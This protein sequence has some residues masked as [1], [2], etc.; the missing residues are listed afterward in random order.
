M[1]A[2]FLSVRYRQRLPVQKPQAREYYRI[3]Y[4]ETDIVLPSARFLRPFLYENF[5]FGIL[6]MVMAEGVKLINCSIDDDAFSLI[7]TKLSSPYA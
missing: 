5:P 3:P 4:L 1:I 6:Y 7:F 2:D